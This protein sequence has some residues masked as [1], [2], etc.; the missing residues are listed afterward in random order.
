MLARLSTARSVSRFGSIRALCAAAAEAKPSI[1]LN[2]DSHFRLRSPAGSQVRLIALAN[3]QLH[4]LW[5]DTAEFS[6]SCRVIPCK[7]VDCILC[8]AGVGV[9]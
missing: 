1:T 9:G 5:R 2:S 8:A 3:W 7:P 4:T 6:G